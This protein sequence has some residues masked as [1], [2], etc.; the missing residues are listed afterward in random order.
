MPWGIA[1][2]A[3]MAV[4]LVLGVGRELAGRLHFST[5]GAILSLVA[6]IGG[7]LVPVIPIAGQVQLSVGAFV[8]PLIFGIYI[9]ARSNKTE[10][11]RGI[12]A[13]LATGGAIYLLAFYM[14][15]QPQGYVDYPLLV[16]GAV[17]GIA[18]FLAGY[19]APSAAAGV[20]LGTLLYEAARALQI[21]FHYKVIAPMELGR[22]MDILAVGLLV[23]L[24]LSWLF[25]ES[26]ERAPGKPRFNRR[27]GAEL[28]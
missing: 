17:A 28:E 21:R 25:A 11:F 1:L 5:R 7:A 10:V 19:R 15:E 6:L 13:A 12:L 2:L 26:R 16:Y 20:L 3:A 22:T 14:Y 24:F 18:A 8:L 9:L 23:G 4:L 27:K